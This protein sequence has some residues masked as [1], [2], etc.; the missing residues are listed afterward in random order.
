MKL[1]KLITILIVSQIQIINAQ[2]NSNLQID[3]FG[4]TQP[5]CKAVQFSPDFISRENWL[6]LNSYFSPDGKEFY[7]NLYN[8]TEYTG[9]ATMWTNYADGKWSE[10][11]TLFNGYAVTGISPDGNRLYFSYYD[12]SISPYGQLYVS[13][14]GASG[15]QAPVKLPS[16][17]NLDNSNQWE[18]SEASSGTLYFSSD[19]AGGYGDMDIYSSELVNGV[20]QKAVNLGVPINTAEKDECPY[21]APD[22][23][24][25]VFN[26]W[27]PNPNFSLNNIY[28]T[29]R[30]QDGS[31][32][33]PKDLGPNV[34]TND[35]DV[36]PF[37]TPDGK[38]LIYT[39]YNYGT[40]GF[41]RLY[42][43]KADFIDSLRHTDFAPY[44][45][46][47]LPN[48][49]VAT[50]GVPFKYQIPDSTFY[51]DDVNDTLTYLAANLLSWLRFDPV[52]RTFSGTPTALTAFY[53][54]I[55]VTV[56]DTAQNTASTYFL[57][58]VQN[59]TDVKNE[60]SSITGFK[61]EQNYPNP[62]NPATIISYQLPANGFVE[63]KIFD[64]LGREVKTLVNQIQNAGN[65]EIQFDGSKLNSGIYLCRLKV[66]DFIQV[67]KMVLLK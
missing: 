43:A 14:R 51:D 57:L 58:K 54:T 52:T 2:Y 44:C 27:K 15:W 64:T 36:Y 60:Q 21:I 35:R 18:I 38:F 3:Y 19:R 23:S 48:T 41:G 1:L 67:N 16:P 37:I 7:F 32:T 24:F 62:F 25:M 65:H 53:K 29:Y 49:Q 55:T 8:N 33:N 56:S 63:L 22:E 10:P 4:Q 26:S 50:L 31:W 28:I 42:W 11:D 66:N 59:P 47:P 17:I 5:G 30:K 13:T 39:I 61:L 9:V 46:N 12:T 6:A 34:N 40:A 20:Y 45:K